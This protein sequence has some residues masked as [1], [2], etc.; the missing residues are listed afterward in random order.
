MVVAA[1]MLAQPVLAGKTAN[2][3]MVSDVKGDLSKLYLPNGGAAPWPENSPVGQADYMDIKEVSISK[4]TDTFVLTMTM[5][6]KDL[7]AE[8][9]AMPKGTNMLTWCHFLDTNLDG[10]YDFVIA[11]GWD[12][13]TFY[14]WNVKIGNP[15]IDLDPPTWCITGATITLRVDANAIGNPSSLALWSVT[16][17][18]WSPFELNIFGGWFNV[19]IPDTWQSTVWPA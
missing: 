19:D 17:V 7:L 13:S 14:S 4:Q 9:V 8:L 18:Y 10:R 12:G 16:R 3:V 5:W 6:C 11:L 2:T 1:L 15:S